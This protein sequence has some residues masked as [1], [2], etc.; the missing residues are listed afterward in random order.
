MQDK[1]IKDAN[2]APNLEEK[3][4]QQTEDN[5]QHEKLVDPGNEHSHSETTDIPGQS[6]IPEKE[7]GEGPGEEP[8]HTGE[9][10]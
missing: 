8:D 1:E 7:P 9:A 2:V 5:K 3:S 10:G 4:D 6:A